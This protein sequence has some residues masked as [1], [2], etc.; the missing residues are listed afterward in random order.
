V[1]KLSKQPLIEVS[2]ELHWKNKENEIIDPNYRLLIGSLYEHMKEKFPEYESLPTVHIPEEALPPKNKIIQYRFWSKNKTWPVVQLGHRILTV[3]MNKNY[4][5]WETFKPIIEYVVNKFLEAYPKKDALTL[6]KLILR[7]LDAF[8]FN[9][10]DNNI[11]E[12]LKDKLHTNINIDFGEDKRKQRMD[13]KPISINF[14]LTYILHEPEGLLELGFFKGTVEAREN[15][16]MESVVLSQDDPSINPETSEI[17]SWLDKAHDMTD[18]VF[19]QLIRGK[20][21]EEELR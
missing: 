11:L 21:E 13:Y 4:D 10:I 5:K 16:I 17:M 7:Y 3:N 1:Y 8:P 6:E 19:S 14:R 9:F 12:F 20:L 18:F 15:L 2:F